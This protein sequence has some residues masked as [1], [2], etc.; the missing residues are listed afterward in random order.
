MTDIVLYFFDL[1]WDPH[2]H[3]I[4]PSHHHTITPGQA[5]P[6]QGQISRVVT[7]LFPPDPTSPLSSPL[8]LIRNKTD[9]F[10]ILLCSAKR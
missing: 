1:Y 6:H 8:S 9:N 3:T 5:R 4:T 2:H 10:Q 7:L